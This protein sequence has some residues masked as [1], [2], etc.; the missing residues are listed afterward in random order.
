M[1]ILNLLKCCGFFNCFDRR[2]YVELDDFRLQLESSDLLIHS[3]RLMDGKEQYLNM[4]APIEKSYVIPNLRNFDLKTK[5]AMSI[6]NVPGHWF[7]CFFIADNNKLNCLIID[8]QPASQ[9]RARL[10]LYEDL[11]QQLRIYAQNE[12]GFSDFHSEILYTGYQDASES[13]GVYVLMLQ[14]RLLA[15]LEKNGVPSTISALKSKLVLSTDGH[16]VSTRERFVLSQAN[17]LLSDT[18][19]SLTSST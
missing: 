6:V 18:T 12:A 10:H 1:R 4:T 19:T 3:L 5:P 2:D 16:D 15:T 7:S 14:Q 9:K 11:V 13:C 17:S 8:S